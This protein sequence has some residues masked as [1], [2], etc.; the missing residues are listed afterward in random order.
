MKSTI[1]I[2]SVMFGL[3]LAM[4]AAYASSGDRSAAPA[5]PA[6]AAVRTPQLVV[7]EA[8]SPAAPML[9]CSK[10]GSCLSRTICIEK[11]GGVSS[12]TGCP[13]GTVCCLL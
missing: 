13:S 8:L 9:M 11:G 10:I 3:A 5:Q 7:P 1:K 6:A 12:A 4:T 2:F